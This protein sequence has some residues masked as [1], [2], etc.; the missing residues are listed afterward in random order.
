MKTNAKLLSLLAAAI[1]A[2]ASPLSAQIETFQSQTGYAGNTDT[3]LSGG[4]KTQVFNDVLAITSLTYNFFAGSGGG[5]ITNGTVLSAA[6]G[7]WTGSAINPLTSINL[8]TFAIGASGTGPAPA[9]G[10]TNILSYQNSSNQTVT[11]GAFLNASY[12]FDFTLLNDMNP[13]YGFIADPLKSYALTLTYVSG[14]ANLALGS[15]TNSTAF[16]NGYQYPY[17]PDIMPAPFQN[18]DYVFS[19]MSI[20]PVG[21]SPIIPET[22]TVASIL[23]ALFVAALVGHRVRQRRQVISVGAVAA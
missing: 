14:D 22:S 21:N 15:N 5:G 16:V 13:T 7:E 4:T 9:S 3:F 11:T 18:F 20:V 1:V 19:A 23:G 12:T 10:W 8:G 17:N 2:F 6:F